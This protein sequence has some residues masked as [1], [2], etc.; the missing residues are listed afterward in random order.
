MG[1]II[2]YG[3]TYG[4]GSDGVSENEIIYISAS[5]Y[6]ALSQEEK[7][8]GKIYFI[9]DEDV[10]GTS[11]DSE[12]SSTSKNPVQNKVVYTALSG[13][14]DS[15]SIGIVGG[16]AG[17]KVK[18]AT[19]STSAWGTDLLTGK[20]KATVTIDKDLTVKSI[21][22]VGIN[23]RAISSASDKVDISDVVAEAN[24]RH[25]DTTTGTVN[26]ETVGKLVFY[27]DSKPSIDIP[28]I[29]TIFGE[30]SN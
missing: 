10:T 15:S 21:G 20:Q 16:V 14:L 26:G 17:L 8:N 12:L 22:D 9:E 4:G 27:A 30:T 11:V 24:V 25:L 18:T 7:M 6:D 5:E 19:I 28:I 13:K 1:K 3:V 29:L 23:Y 2:K